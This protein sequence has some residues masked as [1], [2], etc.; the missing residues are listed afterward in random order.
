LARFVDREGKPLANYWPQVELVLTPGP[1]R[2]SNALT[3]PG[4]LAGDAELL[5]NIQHR[6]YQMHNW[7]TDAQGRVTLPG[8]VPG[9][10][11]RIVAL[12]QGEVVRPEFTVRP[13]ETLDLK[14]I[15]VAGGQ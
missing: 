2:Y 4:V 6:A 10:A 14:E 12:G 13:G 5:G 1:Y 15:K 9:V 11:Y 3:K 8:L 7:R